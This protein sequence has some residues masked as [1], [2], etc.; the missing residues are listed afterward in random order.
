MWFILNIQKLTQYT[1]ISAFNTAL[2]N[3][4]YLYFKSRVFLHCDFYL[5]IQIFQVYTEYTKTYTIHT[6]KSNQLLR[7]F[8][9]FSYYFLFFH[10]ISNHELFK[11]IYSPIFLISHVII[12]LFCLFAFK[13]THPLWTVISQINTNIFKIQ[14]TNQND[15]CFQ[16]SCQKKI[17]S[18]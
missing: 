17:F 4:I 10:Y 16:V 11:Q 12:I 14:I 1:L 5:F 6:D 18:L 7:I 8:L 2:F 15:L 3:Y 13:I 9:L